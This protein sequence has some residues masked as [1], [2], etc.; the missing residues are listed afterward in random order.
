MRR[1]QPV[2]ADGLAGGER[3]LAG[4]E[5][6]EIGERLFGG[7]GARQHRSRFAEEGAAGAGQRD[8]PADAVEQLDAV[9]LLERRD[10]GAGRRLGEIQRLRRARHVLA[11]GDADE[12]A[13]LLQRH[14]RSP[15]GDQTHH[16]QT[17]AADE[18]RGEKPER[19]RP[20]GRA[21]ECAG[22]RCEAPSPP[23][24]STAGRSR[25]RRSA[26]RSRGEWRPGC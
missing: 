20:A 5:A 23:S 21:S 19:Q 2:A 13:Q 3:Q 22:D 18:Q 25:R 9:P 15:S 1:R 24:P 26:R 8:A 12:Y 10:R 16:Y 7:R 6:G 11:F 17:D 4:L 14:R